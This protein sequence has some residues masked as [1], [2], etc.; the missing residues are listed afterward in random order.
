MKP[1]GRLQDNL[2]VFSRLESLTWSQKG[3][4]PFSFCSNCDLWSLCFNGGIRVGVLCIAFLEESENVQAVQRNP[5]W[6]L[7]SQQRL[8]KLSFLQKHGY[9]KPKKRT[10]SLDLNFLCQNIWGNKKKINSY[11]YN[12]KSIQQMCLVIVIQWKDSFNRCVNVPSC[13]LITC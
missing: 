10:I 11:F 4:W 8:H 7:P 12:T 5:T 1:S 9:Q 13:Q 3:F 6:V 2:L